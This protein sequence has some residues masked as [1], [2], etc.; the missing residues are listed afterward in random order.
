MTQSFRILALPFTKHAGIQLHSSQNNNVVLFFVGRPASRNET[1]LFIFNSLQADFQI[2]TTRP[3]E[4]CET[5]GAPSFNVSAESELDI[6]AQ[7][8]TQNG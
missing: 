3:V 5:P 2:S 8:T 1:N 4:M 7:F 6:D